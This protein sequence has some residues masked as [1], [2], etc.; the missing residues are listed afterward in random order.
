MLLVIDTNEIAWAKEIIKP[1]NDSR[2]VMD[3]DVLFSF[4]SVVDISSSITSSW[5]ISPWTVLLLCSSVS[6]RSCNSFSD[7]DEFGLFE[8][9]DFILSQKGEP[10]TPIRRISSPNER[11]TSLKIL[12]L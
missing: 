2:V 11:R 4:V 3:D 1:T 6:L 8:V 5:R 10:K 7:K 12:R 9:I